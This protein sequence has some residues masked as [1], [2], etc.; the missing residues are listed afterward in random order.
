M[1]K[2]NHFNSKNKICDLN[3]IKTADQQSTIFYRIYC[4]YEYS[5]HLNFTMI[6]GGKIIS[7]VPSNYSAQAIFDHNFL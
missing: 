7:Q 4:A 6:L 5:A 2:K 3:E 1:L